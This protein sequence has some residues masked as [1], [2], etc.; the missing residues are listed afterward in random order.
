MLSTYIYK[1]DKY[2]KHL[3]VTSQQVTRGY[4]ASR[5]EEADAFNTLQP[6]AA[7]PLLYHGIT[8]SLPTNPCKISITAKALLLMLR[9]YLSLKD[10]AL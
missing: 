3:G 5:R 2:V 9:W 1:A 7:F 10:T 6:A 8:N 4:S